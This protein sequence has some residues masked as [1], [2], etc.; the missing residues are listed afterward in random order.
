MG[1]RETKENHSHQFQY[2]EF[3]HFASE[4][5]NHMKLGEG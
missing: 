1:R 2:V 3:G 4:R 5:K